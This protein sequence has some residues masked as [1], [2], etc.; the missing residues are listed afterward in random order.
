MSGNRE[1]VASKDSFNKVSGSFFSPERF[2]ERV[3]EMAVI[4]W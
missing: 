4:K 3:G 2:T 1:C